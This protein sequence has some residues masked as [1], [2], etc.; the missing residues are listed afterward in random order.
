MKIHKIRLAILAI[1]ASVFCSAQIAA[2]AVAEES[3][4]GLGT[5]NQ[6]VDNYTNTFKTLDKDN[7]G[8]LTRSEA[9]KDPGF[10]GFA[11]ADKDHD[12]TL[13]EKEYSTQRSQLEKKHVKRTAS[14]SA[15]TAKV[16][17]KII[18][19][20]GLKGMQISVKTYQGVVLL[21]GFVDN[22][23]QIEHAKEIAKN[24]DGVKSVKN[25]L[26]VKKSSS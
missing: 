3:N 18:K 7:D 6:N 25:S 13:D 22:E 15:I 26:L 8:T 5:T 16:K 1:L 21:S 4:G 23:S 17:A 14:D 12:G 10:K 19:D 24:T 20:E 2:A 9:A 11:A